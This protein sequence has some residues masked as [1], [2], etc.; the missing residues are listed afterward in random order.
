M[1]WHYFIIDLKCS[2]YLLQHETPRSRINVRIHCVFYNYVCYLFLRY[3]VLVNNIYVFNYF[4]TL[5][6]LFGYFII[7]G[8]FF[9]GVCSSIVG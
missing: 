1:K 5:G 4:I 6:I 2:G 3:E 8:I 9:R 7:M